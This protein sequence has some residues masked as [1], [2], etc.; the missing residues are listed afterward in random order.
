MS[1]T[2]IITLVIAGI[3]LL[4]SLGY[5]NNVLEKNTLN[6]ARRKAQLIDRQ[7]RCAT[8]SETL[9]GQLVSV[10]LKQLLNRIELKL[11]D[12]LSALD[13]K[14]TACKARADQLRELIGQG[15]ALPVS[16][17]PLAIASETQIKD[18]R[19]QL[20]SLQAQIVRAAEEKVISAVEGKKWLG[21]VRHML[22]SVYI[23]YFNAIGGD[24][25]AQKR[26]NQARLVFERAVQFL[27]KQKNPAPYQQALGEFEELLAQA[28][29]LSVEQTQPSAVQDNELIAAVAQ[30]DED[31][32]QWKK[33]Q[34]YD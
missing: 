32:A 13:P 26:A 1:S 11:S 22:V 19:F 21:Q 14:N 20:E 2:I 8:L 17:T 27:N 25:L 29:S 5:L 9:P 30:E 3:V 7:R 4:L 23:D 16:N 12:E 18:V 6:K 28:K 33:K 10:E 15:Q 34:M 24:F 31:D